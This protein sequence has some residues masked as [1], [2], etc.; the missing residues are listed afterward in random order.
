MDGYCKN[1]GLNLLAMTLAD[2]AESQVTSRLTLQLAATCW[3]V[4]EHRD[5]K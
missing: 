3:F 1:E 4:D 5:C 2:Q